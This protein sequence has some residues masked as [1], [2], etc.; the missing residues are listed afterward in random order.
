MGLLKDY[1][2]IVNALP[3][4]LVGILDFLSG[5]AVLPWQAITPPDVPL[6]QP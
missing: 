5:R 3:D 1:D 2:Q 4:V 6:R